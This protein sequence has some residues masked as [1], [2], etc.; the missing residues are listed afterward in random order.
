MRVFVYG[1]FDIL[2]VGLVRILRYA[3]SLGEVVVGLN[4]DDEIRYRKGKN[5]PFNSLALRSEIISSLSSV[6]EVL[7]YSGQR[8]DDLLMDMI[9]DRELRPGIIVRGKEHIDPKGMRDPVHKIAR[10]RGI[11]LDFFSM[12]PKKFTTRV[13]R[14]FLHNSAKLAMKKDEEEVPDDED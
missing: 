10:D 8:P 6:S 1:S 9:R 14:Q 4:E 2:H 7:S 12:V 3:A 13:C 5:R 11:A